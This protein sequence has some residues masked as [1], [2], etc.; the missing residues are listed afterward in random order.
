MARSTATDL[1]PMIRFGMGDPPDHKWSDE[2]LLKLLNWAQID[3]V[4]RRNIAELED[5]YTFTTSASNT[6]TY[7]MDTANILEIINVF[8]NTNQIY[9]QRADRDTFIRSGSTTVWD[10]SGTPIHYFEIK[11]NSSQVK[12]IYLYP[13]STATSVTVWY[14]IK[15]TE[16]VL[17]PASSV[18]SSDL[19]EEFDQVLMLR[20][21]SYALLLDGQYQEHVRVE[22]KIA[23]L[24]SGI[25]DTGGTRTPYGIHTKASEYSRTD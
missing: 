10:D 4:L 9:L 5:S 21:L 20:A 1:I 12:Q 2:R 19:P 16:M 8:D 22:Q 17:S 3:T 24:S 6:Y 7:A 15:P 11:R 23:V 14:K 18:Q 25:L 13:D